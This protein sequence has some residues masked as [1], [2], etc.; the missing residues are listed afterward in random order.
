MYKLSKWL[1]FSDKNKSY[2]PTRE[3][4][5]EPF[6]NFQKEFNNL[7]NSFCRTLPEAGMEYS[8]AN[9]CPSCDIV[10]DD[11]NFKVEFEMPGVDE[12]DIKVAI[13]NGILS[14][15]A[16]KKTS[17]KNEGKNYLRREISFGAWERQISL[18]EN[19]D[20]DNAQS[21]FKKGMLWVSIPKKEVD[22]ANVIELEVKK[23]IE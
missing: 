10:E 6:V 22:K 12:Q 7:F 3:P 1:D 8:N 11:K 15:K 17:S 14:V 18:P 5:W 23:I 19:I 16:Q 20:I 9:L 21:S 4:L 13:S 2:Y